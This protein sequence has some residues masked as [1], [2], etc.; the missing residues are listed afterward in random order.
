VKIYG[1]EIIFF[2]ALQVAEYYFIEKEAGL[3]PPVNIKSESQ[4]GGA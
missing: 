3:R 1:G 2:F 4:R